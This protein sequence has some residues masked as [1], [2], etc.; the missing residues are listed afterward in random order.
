[1]PALSNEDFNRGIKE[2]FLNNKLLPGYR[3]LAAQTADIVRGRLGARGL[4]DGKRL[5][6]IV[7]SG[8]IGSTI[9]AAALAAGGRVT[10]ENLR[11]QFLAAALRCGAERI[12]EGLVVARLTELGRDTRLPSAIVKSFV[13]RN[14]QAV[15]RL[16]AAQ[17]PAEVEDIIADIRADVAE[18]V[19]INGDLNEVY[20]G[21]EGR[22]RGT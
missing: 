2:S 19:R 22:G 14:P 11:Q 20:A 21:L 1:M 6:Y 15:E 17:S 16:A 10:P 3:I 8:F 5:N 13:A 12:V 9:N 7:D 18:A 4:P